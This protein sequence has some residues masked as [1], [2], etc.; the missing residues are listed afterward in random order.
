M[1]AY[2]S[3]NFLLRHPDV[4]DTTVSLSGV[5]DIRYMVGSNYSEAAV[6]ENSPVDY[7]WNQNDSWFVDHYRKDNI[8]IVTGQGN[9]EEQ[10]IKD[11]IQQSIAVKTMFLNDDSAIA[12]IETVA[13]KMID[14]YKAGGKTMPP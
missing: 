7:I 2:H 6:Y 9:W 1:G 10:S 13:Q 11:T 5:Y 8:I 3:L 4:F 12:K 14:S